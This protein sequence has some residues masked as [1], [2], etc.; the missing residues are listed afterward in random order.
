MRISAFTVML[1]VAEI[2]TTKW[3]AFYASRG[4]YTVM[5]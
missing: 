2:V 5:E 4:T 1:R 3:R